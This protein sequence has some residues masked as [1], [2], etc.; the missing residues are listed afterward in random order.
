MLRHVVLF[1]WKAETPR[2]KIE[3]IEEAFCSL[4]SKIPEI[5]DFEWG[6][7]RKGG[8]STD[9]STAREELGI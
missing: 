8:R 4:P 3:E 5:E 9:I 6:L 7:R 2:D 1:N